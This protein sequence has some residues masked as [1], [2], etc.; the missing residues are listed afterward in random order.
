MAGGGIRKVASDGPLDGGRLEESG[1]ADV[2]AINGRR[3]ANTGP[4]GTSRMHVGAKV[5]FE[6]ATLRRTI[7]VRRLQ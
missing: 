5:L 6:E 3:D 1:Q 7:Y 2:P 4:Y